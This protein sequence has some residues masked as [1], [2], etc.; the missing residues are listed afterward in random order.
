[1]K[2]ERKITKREWLKMPDRPDT[3]MNREYKYVLV[4]PAG[5]KHESGWMH[6]AIIGA[7]ADG[8]EMKY[9]I[10]SYPDDINWIL[11]SSDM[12]DY[13]LAHL[14]T[15]CFYPSGVLKFWGRGVF[16]VDWGSSTD[17]EFIPRKQF[18]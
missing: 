6:I 2:E 13:T 9:E 15:D 12:G 4:V 14:R 5:T 16:K 3:E 10:C 1:M 7:W 8:E 11:P 18:K 17:I